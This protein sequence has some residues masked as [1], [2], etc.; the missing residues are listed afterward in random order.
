MCVSVLGSATECILYCESCQR[1]KGID[2][3]NGKNT[4]IYKSES[5]ISWFNF[6][7]SPHWWG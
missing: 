6:H 2:C 5:Q 7:I 3:S 4:A 1:L